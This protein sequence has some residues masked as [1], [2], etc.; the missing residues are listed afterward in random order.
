MANTPNWD[1]GNYATRRCIDQGGPGG[2]GSDACD[3]FC[4]SVT[5]ARNLRC[6]AKYESVI[7]MHF[8]VP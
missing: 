8:E 1:D 2:D 6:A 5:E 7:L 4:D 3:I